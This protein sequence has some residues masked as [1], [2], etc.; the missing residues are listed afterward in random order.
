MRDLKMPVGG[1]FRR[2]K[3]QTHLLI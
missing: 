3:K 2:M 1:G